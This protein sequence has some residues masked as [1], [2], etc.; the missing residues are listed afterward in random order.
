MRT[1]NFGEY[2]DFVARMNSYH[3][4]PTKKKKRRFARKIREDWCTENFLPENEEYAV[5]KILTLIENLVRRVIGISLMIR[6]L[7]LRIFEFYP[8]S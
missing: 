2:E 7:M 3:P 4:L 5:M 8:L 1:P 6:I